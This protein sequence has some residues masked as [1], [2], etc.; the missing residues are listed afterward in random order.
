MA[1]VTDSAEQTGSTAGQVVNGIGGLTH[2]ADRLSL[3]V[4]QFVTQIRRAG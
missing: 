4:D 1:A 2:E 3:Q